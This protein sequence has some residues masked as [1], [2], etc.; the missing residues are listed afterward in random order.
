MST[1]PTPI[2]VYNAHAD[3]SS[4]GGIEVTLFVSTGRGPARR[5]RPCQVV[6]LDEANASELLGTLALALQELR[7]RRVG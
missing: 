6:C 4:R 7:Q 5:F 1:D 3:I 2:G